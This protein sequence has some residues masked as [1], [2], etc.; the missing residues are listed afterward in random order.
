MTDK[1]DK[2]EKQKI[3]DDIKKEIEDVLNDSKSSGFTFKIYERIKNE[4]KPNTSEAEKYLQDV[5]KKCEFNKNVD[6]FIKVAVI[7]S[8]YSTN[9]NKNIGVVEMFNFILDNKEK[10]DAIINNNNE[11]EI[12]NDIQ[13]LL[14]R[15]KKKKNSN[16]VSFISKYLTVHQYFLCKQQHI[17]I[18]D[19]VVQTRLKELKEKPFYKDIIQ[20]YIKTRGYRKD[21]N[22]FDFRH[23]KDGYKVWYEIIGKIL[24][25]IW[26]EDNGLKE[27]NFGRR[28]FDWYI[29]IVYR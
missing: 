28:D 26:K 8:L 11:E 1:N 19:S 24:E 10:V 15:L 9:L 6:I 16:N 2:E 3:A 12:A 25:A 14:T 18:C 17:Q 29:W 7:D 20:Q 27:N 23:D 13:E 22:V 21:K 5:I 4:L